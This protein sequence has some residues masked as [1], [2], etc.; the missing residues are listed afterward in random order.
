M[1]SH[2]HSI[3]H[4]PRNE[5]R[6]GS[7]GSERGKAARRNGKAPR[8]TAL[9]TLLLAGVG[10]SEVEA[11][12]SGV[13]LDGS[14][15]QP[16]P[17]ALVSLQTTEFRTVSG[18]DGS[19]TL[20]GVQG[21]ALV[22]VAAKAG[23]YNG[24]VEVSTPANDVQILLDPV[25]DSENRNY[26]FLAPSTCG[27]CHPDQFEQWD[28]SPMAQAGTNRWVYDTYDGSGT[29]QGSGGFVYTRDSRYAHGNPAS[30]CAACHQP[31]PWIKQ[32]FRALEE[33]GSLSDGALHGI[34]CEVC[35]K[36]AHMDVSRSNFPGIFPGVV[37]MTLPTGPL[38]EQVE[39]GL[40]GDA[41]YEFPG[42]MRPSYQPQLS[43]EVCAAC[44]QDKN[45][46]DEDGNFEEE[47]GVLSEATYLEWVESP[48]G[49][50]SSPLYTTC[51]DCHMPSYGA[52]QACVVEDAPIRDPETIRGH[53]IEGTTAPFLDSAVELDLDYA[54]TDDAITAEVRIHNSGTGH[55]VP[56]GVTIRNM[57][58]LVDA[59]IE[60]N[61]APLA[62]LGK[63]TVHELGGVGDPAR[64]YFAGLPGKLFAKVNHDSTGASPTFYTDATGIVFDNRIPALAT[65]T[66]QYVFAKP[67]KGT[68]HLRARL[69]YRRAWRDLVDA[70]G[71]TADGH[72]NPL[73]DLGPDYGHLM[74]QQEHVF[75]TTSD[76]P[77]SPLHA[78][79]ALSV[80]PNPVAR[81]ASIQFQ[82]P[83]EGPVQ[84]DLLDAGGRLVTSLAAERRNA[85]AHTLWLEPRDE[86][87]RPLPNG[88]YHLRLRASGQ[89]V[90][91]RVVILRR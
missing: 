74:A 37:T 42:M 69:L 65:D 59:W 17:G 71:W 30:E 86:N 10:A 80:Q 25:P 58:L 39:Y 15:L 70:K 20:T 72:G 11:Q 32:P 9:L 19:F 77:D 91:R 3:V 75:S 5:A 64:G 73:G 85:G 13:V 66:T 14:S 38:Y 50:P 8:Y 54:S 81:R 53:R 33:I 88:S 89:E 27:V 34:S 68:V 43:A 36:V 31:E 23:Y 41:S 56:S 28:G 49:D 57:I 79:L 29:P 90:V 45:D 35:H 51:V 18:A 84:L 24:P 55:H 87:A 1:N 76:A 82:V 63:Q 16:L 6:L 2:A 26:T 78:P 46:P 60:E 21:S 7:R 47:N 44:H 61:G 83:A 12:V 22:I 48:Y 67:E 52:T 62:Y 40:L 4:T